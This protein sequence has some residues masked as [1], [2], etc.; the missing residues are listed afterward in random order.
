M[1]SLWAGI[2]VGEGLLKPGEPPSAPEAENGVSWSGLCD[3]KGRVGRMVVGGRGGGRTDIDSGVA[4]G[5]F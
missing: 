3:P 2:C 1:K 5:M 4:C